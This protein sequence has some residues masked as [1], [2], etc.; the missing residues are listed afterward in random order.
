MADGCAN[1][2]V[3]GFDLGPE[4]VVDGV[5]RFGGAGGCV[6]GGFEAFFDGSNVRGD[7]EEFAEDEE[8]DDE[9]ES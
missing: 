3:L 4:A 8:V 2:G 9:A 6:A 5:E 1:W 7:A